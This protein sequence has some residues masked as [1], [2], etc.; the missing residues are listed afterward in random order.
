MAFYNPAYWGFLEYKVVPYYHSWNPSPDIKK[1][2]TD[3]ISDEIDNGCFTEI[4][5]LIKQMEE[6]YKDEFHNRNMTI[7]DVL[8]AMADY[9]E[10][11]GWRVTDGYY[12]E[13][14]AGS[15]QYA[16]TLATEENLAIAAITESYL[17]KYIGLT[18]GDEYSVYDEVDGWEKR[19]FAS[20]ELTKDNVVLILHDA[21][22]SLANVK[23]Y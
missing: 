9:I 15:I 17:S 21:A 11:Y 5:H 16:L 14:S 8:L 10:T 1:Y 12:E 23:K 18:S 6:Q 20:K 3:K 22:R 13:Y 2:Y 19:K 4:R 7:Q